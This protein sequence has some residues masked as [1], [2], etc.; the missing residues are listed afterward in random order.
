LLTL[1]TL[2]ENQ[3]MRPID[4]IDWP[5]RISKDAIDTPLAAEA[6]CFKKH[7]VSTQPNVWNKIVVL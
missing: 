1:L 2:G 5:R 4:I 6:V 3:L 7:D